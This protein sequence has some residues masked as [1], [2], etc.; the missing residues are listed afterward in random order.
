MIVLLSADQLG[1]A[2]I[3]LRKGKV[4]L[5]GWRW[6]VRYL[7]AGTAG[8]LRDRTQPAHIPRLA[9]ELI[10]RMVVAHTLEPPPGETT[11][12]TVWM[13]ARAVGISPASVQQIRQ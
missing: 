2:E 3:M 6:Q 10:E 8:L 1:L 12:W 11:H 5:G 9:S 7:E 4:E 13:M